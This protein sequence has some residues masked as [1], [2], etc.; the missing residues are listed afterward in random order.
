MHWLVRWIAQ[1]LAIGAVAAAVAIGLALLLDAL[2]DSAWSWAQLALGLL[3]LA[4]FLL[5]SIF[6]RGGIDPPGVHGL[7][8]DPHMMYIETVSREAAG[9]INDSHPPTG[10]ATALVAVLPPAVAALV[11][12]SVWL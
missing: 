10:G 9:T 12:V 7:R 6:V 1:H 4:V 8:V 5:M 3:A 11:I 2:I